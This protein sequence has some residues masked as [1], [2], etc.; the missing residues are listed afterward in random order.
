M[1]QQDVIGLEWC[2]LKILDWCVI[3]YFN[4]GIMTL[5]LGMFMFVYLGMM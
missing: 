5:Q 2:I 3:V 1:G 4:T